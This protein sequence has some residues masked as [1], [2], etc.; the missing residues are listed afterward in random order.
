MVS[1]DGPPDDRNRARITGTDGG[2]RIDP[3]GRSWAV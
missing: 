1:S 2:E 3:L